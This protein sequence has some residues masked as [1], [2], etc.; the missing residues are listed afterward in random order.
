MKL[1]AI[2]CALPAAAGVIHGIVL[3]EETGYPLARTRVALTAA[4]RNP[5]ETRGADSQPSVLTSGSGQFIF[6]GLGEGSY[7]VRAARFGFAP[8]A[9]GARPYGSSGRP[10]ALAADASFFV[11]IRLKRLPAISGRVVDENRVGLPGVAVFAYTV[12]IPKRI[13]GTGKADDRGAYRIGGLQPGVYHVRTSPHTLEDE[14]TLLPT[15][16]PLATEAREARIV[17]LRL[18]QDARDVDVQPQPGRLFSVA[19]RVLGCH[20]GPAVVTLASGTGRQQTTTSCPGAFTFD[21]LAPGDYELLAEG[22]MGP[23]PGAVWRE[24]FAD[25]DTNAGLLQIVPKPEVVVQTTH[26]KPAAE[27]QPA[28]G[29]PRLRIRPSQVEVV[30]RRRDLAGEGQSLRL[31]RGP[32]YLTPGHWEFTATPPPGSFIENIGATRRGGAYRGLTDP[33]WFGVSFGSQ[34]TYFVEVQFSSSAARVS[35]K[36][37]RRGGETVAAAPVY[38]YPMTPELRRRAKGNRI[39]HSDAQGSYTIDGLPPGRYL[40]ASSFEIAEVNEVCLALAGAKEIVLAEGGL[41]L[42]LALWETQ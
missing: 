19:G 27:E 35:G 22:P 9:W 8:T 38:L 15:F 29:A 42:T 28:G 12:A 13:A 7:I 25:R 41:D 18:D 3:E 32:T 11:E 31:D 33:E 5:G 23:V 30:A 34:G 40:I 10:I 2:A 21:G 14:L 1:L 26:G 36:V 17:V 16:A 6:S 20:G 37:V 39:V 4:P 24:F